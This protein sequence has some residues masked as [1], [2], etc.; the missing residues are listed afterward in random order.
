[1]YSGIQAPTRVLHT[2]TKLYAHA[3]PEWLYYCSVFLQFR[4]SGP[5]LGRETLASRY[6]QNP[7]PRDLCTRQSLRERVP[8]SE[9]FREGISR[10]QRR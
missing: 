9:T 2:Q 5:Q 10:P 3:L 1:M 4:C 8:L 7:L 6:F